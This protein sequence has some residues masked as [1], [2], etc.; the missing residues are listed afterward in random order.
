MSR[1]VMGLTLAIAV[2][3][4]FGGARGQEESAG[5][6]EKPG[7]EPYEFHLEAWLPHIKPISVRDVYSGNI[8]TGPY[9]LCENEWLRRGMA[10]QFEWGKAVPTDV[11][12]WALG[13]PE[14][15][16]VTKLGGLPYRAA[17]QP[18]PMRGGKPLAFLAQVNFTKSKDITGELPGDVLLIFGS[19]EPGLCEPHHAEWQKL[20]IKNLTCEPA[21]KTRVRAYH[22]Y[23]CRTTNYPEAKAK[24][25]GN[26]PKAYGKNVWY[27]YHAVH[28]QATSIG[29]AP[30]FIQ[31]EAEMSGRC[32]CAISSITYGYKTPWPFVGH[33]EQIDV[34]QQAEPGE[35]LCMGDVGCI[36]V[37]I[38]EDGKLSLTWSCY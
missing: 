18:W 22:G 29:T 9:D 33:P 14:D 4:G 10:D 1:L 37:F 34:N 5:I 17:D 2:L 38:E 31:N 23:R 20:G 32:L 15:R 21:V 27:S 12:I 19:D 30:F 3:H 36:Y 13:E 6:P 35:G 24:Y 16:T 7:K 26:Y 8:V 11:F 25:T 28:Y